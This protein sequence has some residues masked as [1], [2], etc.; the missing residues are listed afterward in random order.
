MLH[1]RGMTAMMKH[2]KQPERRSINITNVLSATIFVYG[3]TNRLFNL[4]STAHSASAEWAV[5]LYEDC[6]EEIPC[7]REQSVKLA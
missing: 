7:K 5:G 2:L 1:C 4:I 3:N 6:K